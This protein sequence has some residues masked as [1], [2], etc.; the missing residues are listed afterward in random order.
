MKKMQRMVNEDER[1][2][3]AFGNSL[4]SGLVRLCA[5]GGDS[6]EGSRISVTKRTQT[7]APQR[8]GQL[9]RSIQSQG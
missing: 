5:D 3:V 8:E 2:S 6:S 7:R 9:L 4:S 1:A